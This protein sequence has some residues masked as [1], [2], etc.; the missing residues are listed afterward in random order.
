MTARCGLGAINTP[1]HREI[2]GPK[3]AATLCR[4][5]LQPIG[6]K[7]GPEIF[8]LS[9]CN[10]TAVFG[11]GV[12]LRAM[13]MAQMNFLLQL[14]Y[15]RTRTGWMSVLVI[16]PYL[17]SSLMERFGVGEEKRISI[18]KQVMQV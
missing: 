18:H 13:P 1:G 4:W 11:F 6:Q 14:E 10:L 16:S 15:R 12:H 5:A 17:P 7:Y 8:K 3:K 9:H 2:A